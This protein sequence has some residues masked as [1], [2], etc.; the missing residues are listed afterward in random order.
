MQSKKPD[1]TKMTT[2]EFKE[3]LRRIREKALR[4][5]ANQ[6]QSNRSYANQK[7]GDFYGKG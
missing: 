3:E 5:Y 4:I 1:V 6:K 2:E 7:R